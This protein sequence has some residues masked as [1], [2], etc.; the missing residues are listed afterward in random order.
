[1]FLASGLVVLLVGI[2]KRDVTAIDAQLEDHELTAE[3]A[4]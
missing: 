1:L 3:L 2:R 4:A